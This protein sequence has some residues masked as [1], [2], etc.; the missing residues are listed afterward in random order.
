[1]NAEVTVEEYFQIKLSGY[2]EALRYH[3]QHLPVSDI[4]LSWIHVSILK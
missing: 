2:A 4:A 1:M 3:C